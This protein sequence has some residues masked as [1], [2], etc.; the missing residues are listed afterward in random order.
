[1]ENQ[2][3]IRVEREMSMKQM[4]TKLE[5]PNQPIMFINSILG[6]YFF[7]TFFGDFPAGESSVPDS[8]I[9]ELILYN[10]KPT[11]RDEEKVSTTPEMGEK[12]DFWTLYFDGSKTKEGVRVGCLLINPKK[13]KTL[14][15]CRLEVKCTNNVAEYEALI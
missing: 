9:L 3:R 13:N 8:V 7:D 5:A 6:N 11:P 4:V 14:I 1:M 12:E 10:H 2:T 15:T